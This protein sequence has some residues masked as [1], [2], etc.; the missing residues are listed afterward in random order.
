MNNDTG[1][2]S[3]VPAAEN[4]DEEGE[5]PAEFDGME[6]ARRVVG[7]LTGG[8]VKQGEKLLLK[9]ADA[10][11][12][13]LW[14]LLEK[15]LTTHTGTSESQPSPAL[16]T[17]KNNLNTPEFHSVLTLALRDELIRQKDFRDEVERLLG[18]AGT[19][20]SRVTQKAKAGAGS[21]IVQIGGNVQGGFK[22]GG[23]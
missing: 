17:F 3:G 23:G 4:H 19:D 5:V 1:P 12:E 6:L 18:E 22:V 13:R 7:V 15:R 8:L 9:F 2:E 20:S 16:E 21:T 11:A 10:A 14:G